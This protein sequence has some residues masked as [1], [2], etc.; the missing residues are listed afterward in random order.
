[1][2]RLKPL[3]AR[4]TE[5][6]IVMSETPLRP[7]GRT[8]DSDSTPQNRGHP[9]ES[10]DFPRDA[11]YAV[12]P[13]AFCEI[14]TGTKD[15]RVRL[16]HKDSPYPIW[17]DGSNE[18][19]IC[20]NMIQPGVIVQDSISS[21]VLT[22]SIRNLNAQPAILSRDIPIAYAYKYVEPDEVATVVTEVDKKNFKA[23]GS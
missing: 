17:Q 3:L 9:R 14:G 20:A 11:P 10:E 22:V 2:E 6:T 16:Q 4:H 18:Y 7:E 23:R 19:V 21:G 13:A 1:M 5:P 8:R 12:M 15:I